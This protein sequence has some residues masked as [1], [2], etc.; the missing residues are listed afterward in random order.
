M[1]KRILSVALSL[2]LALFA[3]SGSIAVPIVCRPFY[4]AHINALELPAETGWSAAEIKAAYDDVMDYLLLDAPFGTGRLKWSE[5]GHSHFADVRV[6]FRLD[7]RVLAATSLLLAMLFLLCRRTRPHRF[8]GYG[9]SF[10]A[11]VGIF[12]LTAIVGVLGALDFDRAFT[13]FHNIFFPGKTNWLFDPRTDQIILILPE[14]YFRNCAILALG[15][16][17]VCAVLYLILGR[18]TRSE[19]GVQNRSHVH[20]VG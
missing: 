14:A 4:Y 11:G 8:R 1:K 16:L 15:L 20:P 3:I 10:W 9:P 18:K 13:V 7:L 5:A 17:L 6:L 2:V 12:L 19:Q